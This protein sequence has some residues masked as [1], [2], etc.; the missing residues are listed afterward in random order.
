[1]TTHAALYARISS[2][3][4]DTA[5]GVARQKIDC[6]ALAESKG[7]TVTQQSTYVDNDTSATSG[8]P[9]PNY[10]RMMRD[11]RDG[12]VTALVVWD[13]DRLTRTPRELEDII[14]LAKQQSVSLASVGGEIDLATPQGILTAG[15]K[16]QVAR[17]ETEQ[18]VRRVKRKMAERAQTG[19]P[20]G[21][22]AYGWRREQQYDDQGRRLGSRDVL[23]PEQAAVI[24][25]CASAVLAGESL[26][27]IARG[28]NERG[29]P[30]LNSKPWSPTTL[31]HVLL[32]E[33][34]IGQRVHQGQVVGAGDWEPALTDE[35]YRRV[36]ALLTDPT[37]RTSPGPTVRHL[38]SGIARCGV[39]DGPMRI[40]PAKDGRRFPTY[41]CK[42]NHV[43]RAQ[44]DVDAL[45]SEVVTTFL[46]GPNAMLELAGPQNAAALAEAEAHYADVRARLNIAADQYAA[47][48]GDAETFARISARLKPEL[49]RADRARRTVST[50]PDL[51]DLARPDI[52]E[53]WA[54]GDTIPLSRKREAIAR[55]VDV[56]ILRSRRGTPVEDSVRVTGKDRS[57]V[58]KHGAD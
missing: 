30:T 28:L 57:K 14:D 52:A 33:R 41:V 40:Y 5:L 34:N 45:V 48:I 1:M 17:H 25:E 47:G 31:K 21:R 7:W 19:A 13:V 49:E 20:H 54:D 27:S 18:L 16:A 39:C 23:H 8:K 9:R 50:V 22:T 46:A 11:L 43:R 37:R 58:A 35:T 24:R 15:I 3:P 6:L 56:V 32:R 12:R 29:V 26:A 51:L 44:P 10:E 42:G 55:L 53:L 4:N 2:D 36:V 38:L